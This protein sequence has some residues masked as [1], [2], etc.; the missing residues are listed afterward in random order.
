[1]CTSLTL[2]SD[3][4]LIQTILDLAPSRVRVRQILD[5]AATDCRQFSAMLQS[6]LGLALSQPL[7]STEAVD[8]AVDYLT[9]CVQLT[10]ATVVPKKRVCSYSRPWWHLEMCAG[11][12][13]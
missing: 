6:T 7:P 3:H 13:L 8:V 2:S 12:N 1:M 9:T 11:Q 5:W 10:M 4:F